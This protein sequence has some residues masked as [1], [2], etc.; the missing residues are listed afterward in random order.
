[1]NIE[2]DKVVSIDYTLKDDQGV[3][4]D[5]SE[6]NGPL[7][8]IYGNGN[9][10]SGL[11]AALEGKTSGDELSVSIEPKDGYGEYDE[12]MIFEVPKDQFQDSS[13]LEEGM[14]VQGQ[15]KEGQVQVF[16][17][18]SIGEEEV[19]LD[20]NHPLAGYTLHFEVAVTGVRDATP[21]ELDHG[22]VH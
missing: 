20:A 8:F 3:V 1:M 11:E 6:G 7:S 16:T 17:I 2:A 14:Q 15:T 4:I 18:K 9:I 10:I 19:V 21:E 12:T 22:H 13:K 5:S